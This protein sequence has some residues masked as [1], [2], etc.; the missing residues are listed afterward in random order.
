MI[1]KP[2][3]PPLDPADRSVVVSFRMPARVYDRV[4][5]RAAAA[6]VTV[7]EI[8]R[9]AWRSADRKEIQNTRS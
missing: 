5:E 1:R 4:C 9:R 8:L 7:P 3:R 6:R 2:G